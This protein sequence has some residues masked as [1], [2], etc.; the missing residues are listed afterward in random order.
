M[1][2]CQNRCCED[3]R[4]VPCVAPRF[5]LCVFTVDER[6]DA[7]LRRKLSVVLMR[8]HGRNKPYHKKRIG[9]RG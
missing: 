9:L 1:F 4:A 8:A 7:A 2:L 3:D 5:S 6:P